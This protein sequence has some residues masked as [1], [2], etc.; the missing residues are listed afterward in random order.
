MQALKCCVSFCFLVS[1]RTARQ[2]PVKIQT[3][4]SQRYESKWHFNKNTPLSLRLCLT[5]PFSG[6]TPSYGS[7][8]LWS[9]RLFCRIRPRQS[10]TQTTASR[11]LQ[12]RAVLLQCRQEL[13]RPENQSLPPSLNKR[14]RPGLSKGLQWKGV[15][16]WCTASDL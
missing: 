8:C 11:Y 7:C 6:L 5:R 15:W 2:W 16:T 12:V 10:P 3:L 1:C 13:A 14:G 4:C 9:A